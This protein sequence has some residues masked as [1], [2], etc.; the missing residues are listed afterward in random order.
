MTVFLDVPL[1]VVVYVADAF[2]GGGRG[3]SVR[4]LSQTNRA[5]RRRLAWRHTAVLRCGGD[6]TWL[7][8]GLA[9]GGGCMVTLACRMERPLTPYDAH[10]WFAACVDALCVLDVE[11][12]RGEFG[13]VW[14]LAAHMPRLRRLVVDMH[15]RL[16]VADLALCRPLDA[17]VAVEV[18]LRDAWMDAPTVAAFRALLTGGHH[19]HAHP[20]DTCGP[21]REH[22]EGVGRRFLCP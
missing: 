18:V 2:L 9:C 4:A 6:G 16:D 22:A 3:T 7:E 8:A 5:L 21:L 10:R 17:A 1:D 19:H 12:E 11:L 14:T 20:P 15:P 13:A